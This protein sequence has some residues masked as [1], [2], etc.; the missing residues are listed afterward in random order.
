MGDLEM[1]RWAEGVTH[2]TPHGL[3]ELVA[4]LSPPPGVLSPFNSL[5]APWSD[6]TFSGCYEHFLLGF[7]YSAT[8]VPSCAE[9]IAMA[10][11]SG[12]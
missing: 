7:F 2:S 11:C 12:V 6:G 4:A 8:Q 10:T 3:C 5:E 1:R 9:D